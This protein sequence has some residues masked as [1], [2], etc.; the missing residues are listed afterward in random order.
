MLARLV[1]GARRIGKKI[2]NIQLIQVKTITNSSQGSIVQPK[3]IQLYLP[4]VLM[5]TKVSNLD[6]D[7]YLK[8]M[9]NT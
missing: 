1:V 9:M 3:I 5:M 7:C 2:V 8:L 6:Q 4:G